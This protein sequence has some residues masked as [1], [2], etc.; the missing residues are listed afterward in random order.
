MKLRYLWSGASALILF[1]AVPAMADCEIRNLRLVGDAAQVRYDPFAREETTR[2]IRVQ[3]DVS[4]ECVGGLV[5]L[6][7]FP[8]PDSQGSGAELVARQGTGTINVALASRGREVRVAA[9]ESRAFDGDIGPTQRIETGGLITL[10][11]YEI[12]APSGQVVGPGRYVARARLLARVRK[13]GDTF[14]GGRTDFR[15]NVD[16]DPSYRL[17]AGAGDRVLAL[18]EIAPGVESTPSSFSAYANVGYELVFTSENHWRLARDG[19]AGAESG[20]VPYTL[21]ASGTDVERSAGRSGLT[22]QSAAGDGRR[23]HELVAVV[24]P[25]ERAAAGRYSDVVTV[26]IRPKS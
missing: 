12:Y 6:A 15:I 9:L 25:Y 21:R 11:G 17:A 22:F 23:R 10:D 4:R 18:G 7:V 5:E 16:V 13:G 3:A 19:R 14:E 26:E 24:N 20:G 1:A 2:P 8:E